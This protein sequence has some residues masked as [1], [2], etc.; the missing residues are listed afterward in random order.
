MSSGGLLVQCAPCW[1]LLVGTS[2]KPL[3]M[4]EEDDVGVVVVTYSVDADPL[5]YSK[6][7]LKEKSNMSI[8]PPRSK[9]LVKVKSKMPMAN[10]R[11]KLSARVKLK[12]SM[13]TPLL[14]IDGKGKVEDPH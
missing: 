6:L 7:I 14:L 8:A 4:L 11:S 9:L 10:P 5:P 2:T 12:M 3:C 1:P 13:A